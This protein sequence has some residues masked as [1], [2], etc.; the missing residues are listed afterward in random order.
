MPLFGKALIV[1]TTHGK[2]CNRNNGNNFRE[3]AAATC[4]VHSIVQRFNER[5]KRT[6]ILGL[7]IGLLG[8]TL[9]KTES[10]T[11]INVLLFHFRFEPQGGFSVVPAAC[12]FDLLLSHFHDDSFTR[13]FCYDF[14]P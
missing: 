8:S 4:N 14:C 13:G 11:Y 12:F 9:N 2:I 1:K 3:L 7:G 10:G 6:A 5:M